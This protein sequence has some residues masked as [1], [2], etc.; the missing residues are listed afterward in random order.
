MTL[1]LFSADGSDAIGT[2][3]DLSL[4]Y[5]DSLRNVALRLRLP[6][7]SLTMAAL[8]NSA[9]HESHGLDWAICG[10]YEIA[11]AVP[12]L[13]FPFMVCEIAILNWNLFICS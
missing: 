12:P 2:V 8:Q 3:A 9:F 1:R 4:H 10:P 13:G 5:L 11:S 6:M 7:L